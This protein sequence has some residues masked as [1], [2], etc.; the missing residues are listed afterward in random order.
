MAA[1]SN[2]FA[3]LKIAPPTMAKMT[4][5]VLAPW[6][7]LTRLAASWPVLPMVWPRIS[8]IRKIPTA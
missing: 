5:F 4:S 2:R 1:T 8:E 7:L 3:R 6:M